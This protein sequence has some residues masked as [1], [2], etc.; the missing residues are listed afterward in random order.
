M[1]PNLGTARKHLG[2]RDRLNEIQEKNVK[3]IGNI[4]KN[5]TISQQT[6]PRTFF[7]LFALQLSFERKKLGKADNLVRSLGMG[8]QN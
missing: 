5:G 1:V 4:R 3:N 2:V 8:S 7:F 6:G